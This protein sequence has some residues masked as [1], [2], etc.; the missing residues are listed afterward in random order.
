MVTSTRI[1]SGKWF[2]REHHRMFG[3]HVPFDKR[4]NLVTDPYI[5]NSTLVRSSR[6]EN[7]IQSEHRRIL[8][9]AIKTRLKDK[10]MNFDSFIQVKQKIAKDVIKKLLE[11]KEYTTITDLLNEC[12][13]VDTLYVDASYI[14]NPTGKKPQV[15]KRR[16]DTFIPHKKS[17][18]KLIVLQRLSAMP[19]QVAT[20]STTKPELSL[21]E[22][23]VI[24]LDLY[25]SRRL[26]DIVKGASKRVDK[27]IRKRFLNV[28]HK[29][30]VIAKAF[31]DLKDKP[32]MP[33]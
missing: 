7:I 13:Y 20:Q 32:P 21:Y 11:S 6:N 30:E 1:N 15:F 17:Y 3:V 25:K 28:V 26:Y 23:E 10:K 24:V 33:Q 12:F 2:S 16:G 14:K 8:I 19:I 31:E 4:K 29:N 9:K 5:R 22:A 27:K 18:F